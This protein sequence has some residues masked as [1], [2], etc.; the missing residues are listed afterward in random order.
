MKT[1]LTIIFYFL[2]LACFGQSSG[3]DT[4]QS[5]GLRYDAKTQELNINFERN[6]NA[7]IEVDLNKYQDLKSITIFK[8]SRENKSILSGL[9]EYNIAGLSFAYSDFYAFASHNELPKN[10][11]RFYLWKYPLSPTDTLFLP[12]ELEQW[13]N[14]K[15]VSIGCC[16]L[17][18]LN[19][20]DLK[21]LSKLDTLILEGPL[22]E[23]NSLTNL[24]G[25]PYL[26]IWN[27][28]PNDSINGW[29]TDSLRNILDT[30]LPNTKKETWCFPPN[31]QILI[32]NGKTKSIQ[33]IVKGDTLLCYNFVSECFAPNI[34]VE[35][36]EHD[37]FNYPLCNVYSLDNLTASLDVQYHENSKS[38]IAT[39]NHSIISVNGTKIPLGDIST[40]EFVLYTSNNDIDK[41]QVEHKQFYFERTKVYNLITEEKNYFVN[42]YLFADK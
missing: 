19:K 25:L 24:K 11:I 37:E 5:V 15:Y 21:K 20:I 13:P 31:Q 23:V 10:I 35:V 8:Y 36:I 26:G 14:L 34:V 12:K 41:I 33:N 6:L 3:I 32:F 30:L 22:Y 7:T 1:K 17:I 18:S 2:F 9:K 40:D 29:K 16:G 27:D 28:N 4:I 38:V 42:G 39:V